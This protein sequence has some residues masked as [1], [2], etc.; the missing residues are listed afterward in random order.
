MPIDKA[1]LGWYVI[2]QIAGF[3]NLP[4]PTRVLGQGANGIVFDT[5]KGTLLKFVYGRHPREYKTLDKL[6]NTNIAPQLYK[7]LIVNVPNKKEM[8]IL[9]SGFGF[10]T[11]RTSNKMTILEMNK[12]N[13]ITLYDYIM[14]RTMT[15]ADVTRLKAM[16]KQT[17]KQ[18]W[19]RGVLH[20]DLHAA[21]IMV[22][23]DPITK[24]ITKV[25]F[26]D[27]G[28]SQNIEK[29]LNPSNVYMKVRVGSLFSNKVRKVPVY[30]PNGVRSNVNM[31]RAAYN[32][33]A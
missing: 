10:S 33:K 30:G 3:K 27:F 18:M 16:I 9:K 14:K 7:S 23:V 25:W 4:R 12:L 19:S 22:S 15:P 31:L 32:I 26:I 6:K 2:K 11:T 5:K 1:K 28:R 24:K 29:Q 20:G 21:N 13:A 17:A 8:Q